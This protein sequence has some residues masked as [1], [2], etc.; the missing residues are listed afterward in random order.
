MGP[1]QPIVLFD[2]VCN[3]CHGAVR[4]L[5]RHSPKGRFRFLSL[6]SDEAQRLLAGHDVGDSVVLIDDA[7]IH[8]RSTAAL[9]LTRYLN[10]PRPL[11]RVGFLIPRPLRDLVYNWIARNRYRW[12]GRNDSCS[13]Y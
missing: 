3:L 2:G 12:F 1:Q 4:F 11:A 7:G 6:G 8:T 9:R 5:T 13:L 10:F